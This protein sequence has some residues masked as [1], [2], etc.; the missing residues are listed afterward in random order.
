MKNRLAALRWWAE[1]INKPHMIA[2][3]NVFYGIAE[4]HFVVE[5]STA[6]IRVAEQ[7]VKIPELSIRLSLELQQAFGLRRE[8]AL[9][10]IP[11]Y[12]DQS[13][14]LRLKPTWTK[15]GKLREI[16][17]L[18]EAQRELLQRAHRFAGRG[19]LIPQHR[20]YIQQLRIYERHTARA[21]LSKLHGLR[22]YY[23]RQRYEALTG[24]LAPAAG[25]PHAG[26]ER[27]R[28]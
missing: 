5:A 9:K 27:D 13:D 18:T 23:A 22:H 15:R 19:S 28:S 1:K 6:Q 4:R 16:P 25:G 10:F 8:E 14:H 17:I 12:A 21:G 2:P 11:D 7:L 26:A 24:W 20:N 3:D